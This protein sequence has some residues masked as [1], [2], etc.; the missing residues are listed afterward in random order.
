MSASNA[1]QKSIK[2]TIDAASLG[3]SFY[4]G[5]L[6]DATY[7]YLE[8]SSYFSIPDDA[9]GINGQ[10]VTVQIDVWGRDQSK[11]HPTSAIVD[12]VYDAVHEAQLSLDDPYACVNCRVVQTRIFMDPDGITAHGVVRVTALI[13]DTT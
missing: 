6:P 4:D 5:A 3:V 2:A 11:M 10:E 7:P 13:E 9:E 1:L 12:A 8:V